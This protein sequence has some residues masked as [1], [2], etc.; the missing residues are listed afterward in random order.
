MVIVTDKGVIATP[1]G[2]KAKTDIIQVLKRS[3]FLAKELQNTD[4]FRILKI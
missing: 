4:K 3:Q 2:K 1:S